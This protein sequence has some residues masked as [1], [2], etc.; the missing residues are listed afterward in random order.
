[1]LYAVVAI[2]FWLFGLLAILF[3]NRELL[4]EDPFF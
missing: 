4:T 2:H 3:K 1:M